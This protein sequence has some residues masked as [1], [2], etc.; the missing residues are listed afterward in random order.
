MDLK[1]LETMEEKE[2]FLLQL[3]REGFIAAAC[4]KGQFDEAVIRAWMG[5]DRMFADDVSSVIRRMG[6]RSRCYLIRN[7]LN[8][9][10]SW[11]NINSI[12][13][14]DIT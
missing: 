6:N 5:Q 9:G 12:I 1:E 2:R 10:K 7:M 14:N 8:E 13:N 3:G 11:E 4:K